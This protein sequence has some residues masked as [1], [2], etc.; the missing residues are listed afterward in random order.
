MSE[1]WRLIIDPPSP[2]CDNMATDEA[3]LVAASSDRASSPLLRIYG[4]SEPTLSI[5]YLQ[6][7]AP[8]AG[9]GLPMVRRITGGRAL[10]HDDELTY[11]VVAGAESELYAMGIVNCY[12]SISRA[13]VEAL[14][15]FGVDADFARPDSP[16]A[17]RRHNACFA[18]SARYEVLVKGKKIAGSAQRRLR[19]ALLQHGSIIFRFDKALWGTIFGEEAISKTATLMDSGQEIERT[20]FR[21]VFVRKMEQALRFSFAEAGLTEFEEELKS[22]LVRERYSR[23]EWNERAEGQVISAGLSI[24]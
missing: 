7:S 16:S 3:L 9:Y 21:D 15:E 10:L 13:I 2:G 6:K 17:Y 20:L 14:R 18:S 1:K 5:G 19:G 23:K 4:W 22:R 24:A 12:S 11:A 8:F